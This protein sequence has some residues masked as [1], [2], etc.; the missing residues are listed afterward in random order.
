MHLD[1]RLVIYL[2]VVCMWKTFYLIKQ[3]VMSWKCTNLSL[4]HKHPFTQK[5]VK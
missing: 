3:A 1:Y 2:N 4:M 5:N